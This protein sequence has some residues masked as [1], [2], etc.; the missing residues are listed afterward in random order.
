M[1]I[2]RKLLLLTAVPTTM[3]IL[4][5]VIMISQQRKDVERARDAITVR[6]L[7]EPLSNLI[8]AVQDER[9][10][11]AL[12]NPDSKETQAELRSASSR[13]DAAFD[14]LPLSKLSEIESIR[15][16]LMKFNDQFASVKRS[17]T[18]VLESGLD[19]APL[20]SSYDSLNSS[21]RQLASDVI[22]TSNDIQGRSAESSLLHLLSGIEYAAREREIINSVLM[23]KSLSLASFKSWQTVQLGLE[24]DLNEVVE[25][26]HDQNLIAE[27]SNLRNSDLNLN[28]TRL[29]S[30]I[31]LMVRGK[32][33]D[34]KAAEWD[35]TAESRL[36]CLKEIFVAQSDKI[37]AKTNERYA[38]S[39]QSLVLHVAALVGTVL[40]T[41][42][43]SYFF[44]H[45]QF[46]RPLRS[47]ASVANHLAAGDIGSE[48]LTQRGDEIGEVLLAVSKVRSA[49]GRLQ[50]EVTAQ[51]MH[52]ELGELNHRCDTTQ[53]EGTYRQL[54]GA[55]NRLNGSLTSITSEIMTVIAAIGD[56]DLTKRLTGK[57]EGDFAEMQRRFNS[58]IDR[59]GDTLS[60]VRNSNREAYT[61]SDN[62][63]QY[64]QTVARNATEQAAALVE[65]ASSLEEMTAMT[66]QS[67]ESARTAKDVSES[68]RESS[69]RG[70]KQVR[71]LVLAIERI[72][73]VGDEQ[74]T[75][76]KTIDDIAFQTNLLALNAAVE[77]ARAGEAGKGFAVVAD[78]VRNLA[79][80]SAEAANIT[81][82]MTEQ[83][84]SETAVG[85]NLANEVSQILTEICIWA[86][87]SSECVKEI[88]SASSEQ[89]Q[90]IEQ[91]ST[92]VTQLDSALQ[93][94]AAESGETSEEAVR[95]RS[96]L[97]ELDR[98]LTAFNFGDDI[99]APLKATEVNS[100][101]PRKSNR[102]MER[103]RRKSTVART[104]DN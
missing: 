96:R 104:A 45:Y 58:A 88:A 92:S 10:A 3:V 51:V 26:S 43:F 86:E 97:S 14:Q 99:P 84:L 9:H 2:Q 5:S 42:V 30:E 6:K 78:E 65:I 50:D 4:L 37:A 27:L 44:C 17:R 38:S 22:N 81:A 68:T 75:I 8:L 89:A 48:E 31:E 61:T 64:S 28:V 77:A 90:G 36:Q 11:A 40:L 100:T 55:M 76:L 29:R 46:I 82:R 70:A 69:N 80:R 23:Q 63:E 34:L 72:K 41:M 16:T 12:V 15:P 49:I 20:A 13:V 32:S 73:K 102:E 83:S 67:A 25:G 1:K 66:R 33:A 74:T 21:L 85:V 56:G 94:S 35:S 47:L 59:M 101:N 60:Q 24:L 54:A 91:I 79:L 57:Y 71:E 93:E 62:V 19:P 52:A 87:R 18:A 98:L 103:S 95:M 7:V 39:N 53:F